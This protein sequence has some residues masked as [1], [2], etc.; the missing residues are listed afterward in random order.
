[1]PDDSNK[2]LRDN[3]FSLMERYGLDDEQVENC[4]KDMNIVLK[5]E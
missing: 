4:S 3:L 1:M 2:K 5:S